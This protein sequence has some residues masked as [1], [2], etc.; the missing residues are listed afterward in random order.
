MNCTVPH[1]F[2]NSTYEHQIRMHPDDIHKT[3]FRTHNGHYEY[4]IMPFGLSN[5]PSTFQSIMNHIFRPH[6]RKFIL[7]FF[8][9]I[10]VYNKTWADHLGHLRV[11]LA[12]LQDNQF[13][14]KPTKCFFGVKEVE[15]LGHYISHDGVRVDPRKFDAVQQWPT[16]S[17]V[18]ELRGFL[19]LAGYYRKFCPKFGGKAG[20]LHNLTKKNNFVWTEVADSA[21]TSLKLELSSTPILAYQILTKNLQLRRTRRG[22]GLGLF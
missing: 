22:V 5:V 4:L 15:Y 21:F 11:V 6:L 8:D 7:V 16:P 2:R 3:A 12:I 18:T 17:N 13:V 10:L 1:S 14:I 20:P 9:D 19:G